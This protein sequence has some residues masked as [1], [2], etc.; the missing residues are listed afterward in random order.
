MASKRT[1]PKAIGLLVLLA[2]ALAVVVAMQLKP[3]LIPGTSADSGKL[4][5]VGTYKVP[6]LGLKAEER[7][8]AGEDK[9]GRNLFAYG[10]PP[11]PTPDRRPTPTP[12]PTLPPPPPPPPTPTPLCGRPKPSFTMSFMGWIG[13]ERLPVAVFRDGEEIIAVPQG[14][15]FKTKY[16]L[17]KIDLVKQEATIGFVG[18]CD[19]LATLVPMVK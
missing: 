1:S 15:V 10:P 19:Q 2:V 12:R 18:Y 7:E 6:S 3:E 4:P 13:P 9:G 17:R 11:T 5:Q 8:S 14:E 16:V